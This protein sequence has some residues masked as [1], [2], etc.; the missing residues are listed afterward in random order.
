[1]ANVPGVSNRTI[2]VRLNFCSIRHPRNVKLEI[3]IPC[4][5]KS[6]KLEK[7]VWVIEL[8]IFPQACFS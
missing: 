2:G 8:Q 3:C 7:F 1:M 5:E 6:W 4:L